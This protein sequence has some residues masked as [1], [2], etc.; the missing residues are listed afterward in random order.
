VVLSASYEN[1]G[2]GRV[3]LFYGRSR[4]QWDALRVDASSGTAPCTG[5]STACYIP[6]SKAERI[7]VGE[8][9]PTGS[10]INS[11]GRAR[12]V[13]W[14]GD[15]TGDGFGDFTLPGS[16]DVLNRFYLFSGKAVNDATA[17]VA[18]GSALQILTQ[19]VG[20]DSTRFDGFGTEACANVD[21]VG[22]PGRDLVI[23]HPYVNR[24]LVYADGGTTGYPPAP[25]LSILGANNF[26]NGLACTDFNG[27]GRMDI[28]AGSNILSG[29]SVWVLYNQATPGSEF[30]PSLG[31]LSQARLT[32]ST[33]GS[34]GVSVT[35]GDFN[36]DGRPDIAAGD[37]L[38]SRGPR[39][40]I[41]Y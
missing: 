22:G 1:S 39:V 25:A 40:Q 5:S 7:F 11:F 32:S 8:S 10:A 35:T 20:T 28:V 18:A 30:E 26:G 37:N 3:Y 2:Q 41:W 9:P 12:G 38:D 31:G 23:S 27:D 24:L 6:A 21:L 33:A 36:G 17:P 16:R 4:A 15:I 14:L 13:T 19:T 29:G 34:L